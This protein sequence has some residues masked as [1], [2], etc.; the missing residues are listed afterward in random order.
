MKKAERFLRAMF[1]CDGL[2]ERVTVMRPFGPFEVGDV[3]QKNMD[4][5]GFHCRGLVMI[6]GAVRQWMGTGLIEATTQKEGSRV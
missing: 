6:P 1:T 2:P 3:A 5:D 4:S